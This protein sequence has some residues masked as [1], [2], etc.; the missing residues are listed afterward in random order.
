MHRLTW[1]A[2]LLGVVAFAPAASA[3]ELVMFRRAGCP[4]CAMWD[5]E[6]GP[7]YDRTDVG[8]SVPIRFVELGR[9]DD[10]K[11]ALANPV[12]FTPTF[13]LV[14]EGREIGR[15]EGYPGADFFWGLLERLLQ[16][17]A[18]KAGGADPSAD[19]R[20]EVAGKSS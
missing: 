1:M 13:V 3:S 6:I 9:D 10:M 8:R 18:T 4:W 5:R 16:A 19:E 15:I 20:R 2:L 17:P 7:I 12:R 11:V 14:D